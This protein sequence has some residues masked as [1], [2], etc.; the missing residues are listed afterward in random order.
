MSGPSGEPL[1]PDVEPSDQVRTFA[2]AMREMYVALLGEG[3]TVFEA[4][5]I[6]AQVIA[7]GMRQA[8]G[9]GS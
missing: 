1:F 5:S 6:I 3:F 9:G 7:G 4:M 8:Q 2:R